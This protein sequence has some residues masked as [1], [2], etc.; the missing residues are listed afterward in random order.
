[1]GPVKG[2]KKKKKVE[3]KGEDYSLVSGSSQEDSAKWWD[4]FSKKIAGNF[5]NAIS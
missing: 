4:V 5:T 1:M 2:M 3:K